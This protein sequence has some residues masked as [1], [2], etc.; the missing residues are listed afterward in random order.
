MV[1]QISER[2]AAQG[3]SVTVAT[4]QHNARISASINGVKVLSFNV[5]GNAVKGYEGDVVRYQ[6]FLLNSRFDIVTNFA[7]QQWATDIALPLLQSIAGC[8]V[9]VPTGFSGLYS[10]SYR[11]YFRQMPK[12][13][14]QYNMNVFFSDS[15]RDI[16]FARRHGISRMTLIPNGA[17]A[18]EFLAPSLDIRSQLGVPLDH[19]LILHVGSHTWLKGH[20]ETMEIFRRAH[21]CDATLLLVGNE[22]PGGC[23]TDC[24]E[25]ARK[26]NDSASF[27]NDRKR[28]VVTPLSRTETISA[29]Q[30]ADLFLFPSNIECSPIVIFECLASRT[31]F[32]VTDVGN[33]AEII[34]WSDGSGLLLPSD[35]P[36]FLPR[37]GTLKNRV[38]EKIRIM[39]GQAE[40]FTA[41]RANIPGS[42]TLLESL[43]RDKAGREKMAQSGF[44]AWGERFTWETIAREYET[45]YVNL[46]EGKRSS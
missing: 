29:Y 4:E 11:D 27:R 21:L 19:F 9:Y 10:R 13:M 30:A 43:Y 16:S 14:K 38:R 34:L 45:L 2:L 17:A 40:D 44:L 35:P 12:F 22:P 36:S 23:G 25:R 33:S 1:R 26:L 15:Y 31:P 46:I 7:A 32:L 6:R 5:R 37:H 39:L 8:K 20:E 42:V 28:I 18:D 3:H 24:S 41:V